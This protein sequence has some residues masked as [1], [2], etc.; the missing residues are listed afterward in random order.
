MF[1]KQQTVGV[2]VKNN[3]SYEEAYSISYSTWNCTP[4]FHWSNSAKVHENK[5]TGLTT[6]SDW[7]YS[8]M[9]IPDTRDIDIILESKMK[10]Q[11]LLKY[12]LI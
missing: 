9:L 3:L 2:F 11:A 5:D 8:K 7:Y 6:H 4:T 1:Y 10:E 12:L